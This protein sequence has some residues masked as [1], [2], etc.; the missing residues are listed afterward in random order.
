M[1]Q[2][3]MLIPPKP[4]FN[5]DDAQAIVEKLQNPQLI[6]FFQLQKQAHLE[7]LAALDQTAAG[8]ADRLY[9]QA[10]IRY[11]DSLLT[12]TVEDIYEDVN[13]EN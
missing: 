11:I 2:T 4:I 5:E 3:Q 12:I 1:P 10:G 7:R 13:T 8:E 9:F 6:H